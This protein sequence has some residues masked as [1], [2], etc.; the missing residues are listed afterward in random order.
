VNE[1]RK[2]GGGEGAWAGEEWLDNDARTRMGKSANN[3][4]PV[5]GEAFPPERMR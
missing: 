3:A 4:D 1:E 5:L 2:G